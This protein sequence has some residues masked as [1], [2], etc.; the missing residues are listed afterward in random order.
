MTAAVDY[1]SYS[2]NE[3]DL[4]Q[5]WR[6]ATKH[7]DSIINGRRLENASWRKFFQT[8]FGLKTIDPATLDW[9]K[10]SDVV[11]LYG[12]F[13]A[14]EP[15]PVLQALYTTERPDHHPPLK[16]ALKKESPE[17]SIRNQNLQEV[18]LR[19]R[20][21][22]DPDLPSSKEL[23]DA[24]FETVVPPGSSSRRSSAAGDAAQAPP[25]R[26]EDASL[27]A[28]SV[29]DIPPDR[30]GQ[31]AGGR[32]KHISFSEKVQQRQIVNTPTSAEDEG[33]PVPSYG[34]SNVVLTR[35][36]FDSVD[37]NDWDKE[38]DE[39]EASNA[40]H[41]SPH[42]S[43]LDDDAETVSSSPDRH[44]RSLHRRLTKPTDADDTE[45]M[46][47]GAI[48][49]HPI[50]STSPAPSLLSPMSTVSLPP[51]HLKDHDAVRG[52]GGA[53]GRSSSTSDAVGYTPPPD[54]PL[55][56]PLKRTLSDSLI[57]SYSFDRNLNKHFELSAM[58]KAPAAGAAHPLSGAGAW[59]GTSAGAPTVDAPPE[60]RP[61]EGHST[62]PHSAAATLG[63]GE[64][65]NSPASSE[66]EE[67]EEEEGGEGGYHLA[68]RVSDIVSN[69]SE[70]AR[71][72]AGQLFTS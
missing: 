1:L 50:R 26:A 68:E 46:Y 62:R 64:V 39:D 51:T 71:W 72:A 27:L 52:G 20:A 25:A 61:P 40:S 6:N 10:D 22:S 15:L 19:T 29:A 9:Q 5:C 21:S 49:I 7:K 30:P 13:L 43:T 60:P 32:Y 42:V 3:F 47:A 33:S 17:D 36:G 24:L 55:G 53:N 54:F 65:K 8:K 38:E 70:I 37:E 67:E 58:R 44:F 16:P 18:F 59:R 34:K 12:P 11:W 2:F 4:H 23:R 63:G 48:F 45:D 28:P 41:G 66:E 14:Y 35:V 57:R 56:G 31:G 69:A